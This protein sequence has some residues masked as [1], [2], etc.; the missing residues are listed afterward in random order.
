MR[1]C[2]V[3]AGLTG[4]CTAVFLAEAGVDVQ[5]I[6]RADAPLRGASA[7]TEGK[8]HLGYVYAMDA[9]LN[10]ARM[11]LRGAESFRRWLQPLI[12]SGAFREH[13]S[14]PF[15]YAVP[16]STML[17]VEGVRTYFARV[18]ELAKGFDLDGRGARPL[19]VNEL[20]RAEL[21]SLFNPE[22]VL[23]AFKTEEVAIDPLIV[24]NRLLSIL[25][26][27]PR[28]TSRM[29]VEVESVTELTTGYEVI[30]RHPDGVVRER[31]DVIVNAA[32]EQR[33]KIDATLGFAPSRPVI[34]R[35]KC[36]LRTH[37]PHVI[38]ALPTVTFLVGEYGDTVAYQDSAYASWYPT[39]LLLQEVG[40]SPTRKDVEVSPAEQQLLINS[41]LGGLAGLMPGVVAGLDAE[42]ADW[43]VVGGYITAWGRTGINDANSELHNRFEV[44]VHSHG[45]Y[46]SIDTGKYTTAPLFAEEASERILGR[47]LRSSR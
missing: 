35:Y 27:H 28:I 43:K 34:H 4:A 3:G 17:D 26:D 16:D 39:G 33:L 12:G 9:S 1:V 22:C 47:P 20:S 45:N 2:V 38:D 32:W 7:G 19:A 18:S 42:S 23:A 37:A 21:A 14:P 30:G 40:L 6:D 10:T 44:G 29:M 15:L 11:M 25:A 5:L 41:T 13:V 8:L 24:R 36:G 31:C 46:H